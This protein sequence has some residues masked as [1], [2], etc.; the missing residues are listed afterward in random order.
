MET[1]R[2]LTTDDF[3][4]ECRNRRL[5]PNKKGL[6]AWMGVP[7]NAGAEVIGVIS[8]G[9]TNPAI[10]YTTD[11]L[12]VLQAIAD[13]AAG[14]IVKARLLEETQTRA[15]QLAS[16]NEVTRGLTSTLEIDPLLAGYY[17]QRGGNSQL[18]SRKPA[19]GR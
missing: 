8:V 17:V 1:R 10:L 18:R 3:Q 7:L 12:S 14:A 11:Q 19:A 15:R 2:P 6:Y 5:I 9:S 4:Q 16:L 13:Q